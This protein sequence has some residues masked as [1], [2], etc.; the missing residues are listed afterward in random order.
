MSYFDDALELVKHAKNEFEKI[1]RSYEQSLHKK[2]IE[3]ELLIEI[4]NLMENLPEQNKAQSR[5][6]IA[7]VQK[8]TL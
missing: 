8:C 3:P 6:K 1:K 5:D 2:S 7:D 4:K